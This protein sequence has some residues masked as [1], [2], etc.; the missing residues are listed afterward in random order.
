MEKTDPHLYEVRI[1]RKVTKFV[2]GLTHTDRVKVTA[3][4]KIM[5]MGGFDSVYIKTL[6][7][8]VKELIIKKH[9]FVFFVHEH[10]IYLV[11]AFI[12]KTQKTP[13]REINN[14]EKIYKITIKK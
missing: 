11:S 7:G 5:E 10:T 13:P 8:A 6:R 3:N 9:R 1:F 2:D 12:K 4:I 14:A